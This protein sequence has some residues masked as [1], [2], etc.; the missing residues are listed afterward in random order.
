MRKDATVQMVLEEIFGLQEVSADEAGSAAVE[1][2]QLPERAAAL[3][4]ARNKGGD[5]DETADVVLQGRMDADDAWE[6]VVTFTQLDD[7]ATT[8]FQKANI[9]SPHRE[10]R[11]TIDTEGTT[12]VFEI[13]VLIAGDMLAQVGAVAAA[14]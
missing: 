2:E 6:D 9:E 7:T 13:A 12:P 11:V 14:P 3:L 10:Y 1:I 4:V 5:V 8:Q